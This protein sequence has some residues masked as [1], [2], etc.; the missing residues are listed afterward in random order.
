MT[1]KDYLKAVLWGIGGL[2]II[3][4]LLGAILLIPVV[5]KWI[6]YSDISHFIRFNTWFN[7]LFVLIVVSS[8]SAWRA[9]IY[10]RK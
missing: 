9:S 1:W 10:S 4:F 3:E 6:S 2:F 5:L 8:I 7:E